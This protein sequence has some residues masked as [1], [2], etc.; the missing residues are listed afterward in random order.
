MLNPNCKWFNPRI[1]LI[2]SDFLQ[3]KPTIFFIYNLSP[4]FFFWSPF[5]EQLVACCEE[6]PVQPA[7]G[8]QLGGNDPD[9]M[10]VTIILV[11]TIVTIS[12]H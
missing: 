6:H 5:K 9:Q 3:V 7:G 2:K 8:L 4:T 12:D 1:C 11:M 10:V